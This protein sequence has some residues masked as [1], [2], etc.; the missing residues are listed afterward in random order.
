M[1][2]T[3]ETNIH[4]LDDG[5][6]DFVRSIVTENKQH[7]AVESPHFDKNDKHVFRAVLDRH[8]ENLQWVLRRRQFPEHTRIADSKT[9]DDGSIVYVNPR[10]PDET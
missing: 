2:F 9:L 5:K 8:F 3:V 10:Y 4:N 6:G 7:A 1:T